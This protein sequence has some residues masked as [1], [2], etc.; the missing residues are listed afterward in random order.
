MSNWA[1]YTDAINAGIQRTRTAHEARDYVTACQLWLLIARACEDCVAECYGGRS[2]LEV[3]ARA[4][5]LETSRIAYTAYH[6]L[7][8]RAEEQL[9]REAFDAFWRRF[10]CAMGGW[11][12][13]GR[14]KR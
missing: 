1:A 10:F 8:P 4:D 5:L 12:W 13:K 6:G 11:N 3:K 2:E 7:K 9:R 14:A